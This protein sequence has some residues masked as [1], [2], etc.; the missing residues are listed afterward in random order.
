MT[1]R[2]LGLLLASLSVASCGDP[3]IVL[4]DLPGFMRI[5]AGVP[6]RSGDQVDS[7]GTATQLNTPVGLVV[8]ED[9]DL[10]VAATRR[11][12][13]VSSAGRVTLLYRGP[14][15]FD[16]SCLTSPQGI[17]LIGSQALLIADNG[18]DRVWRFDLQT[19][20]ISTFAGNGVNGVSPDGTLAQQA[21][22]SSPSDVV[23]LSDGRVLIPERGAHRIR[24]IT[25]D[26]RLQTLAGTG[27]PGRA[28]DGGSAA[29][30]ELNTPTGLALHAT[31]LYI[32]DNGNHSVRSIDLSSGII[33]TIAGSGVVGFSG[34]GGPAVDAKLN[35]PWAADVSADGRTLFFTEVGNHRVRTLNLTDGT[36]AT[37][38]GTGATPY[39]GNGRSAGETALQTP[40]GVA[41]SP[42]GFLYVADT[43][44]H[45]VWRTPVRF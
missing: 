9:G 20:A 29:M 3:L 42:L 11:I 1:L 37:F 31:A 21:M 33:R 45:V 35:L 26:G 34:D 39:N 10:I 15:C 24:V 19:R 25:S 6:D 8:R 22:L 17:A 36:I 16:K 5:V 12:L 41:L 40:F 14:E 7:L 4:G 32:T 2:A 38:A 27:M 23:V 44:H 43:G 18:A 30:A 13:S 28:G